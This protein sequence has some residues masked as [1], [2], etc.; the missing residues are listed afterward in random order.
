VLLLNDG[1]GVA[2]WNRCGERRRSVPL[3]QPRSA[4]TLSLSVKIAE[5]D[6]GDAPPIDRVHKEALSSTAEKNGLDVAE[7][8]AL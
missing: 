2:A 8:A 3:A 7:R 5:M 4:S 6:T 1:V